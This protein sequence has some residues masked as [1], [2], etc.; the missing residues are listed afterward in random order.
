MADDIPT[1]KVL[2]GDE[3]IVRRSRDA[4][5]AIPVDQEMRSGTGGYPGRRTTVARPVSVSGHGTFAGG[6]QRTLTF[7]PTTREG[8]RFDRTDLADSMPIHVSVDNVW[9]TGAVVSNIVLRSGSPHNYM[10]MAEHIIALRIGLGLDNVLIKMD[11]GDPPLFDRSSAEMVEAIDAAGLEETDA[12]ARY[13][14]VKE[15]VT[16]A[17]ANGSFLT[18]IPARDGERK[19]TVDCAVDFRSAIGKQRILFDVTPDAFRYAALARTNT[20]VG[21]MLYCKTIG[22]I[23]ADIRHLGYTLKNI[24]IAGPRKYV[25]APRLIHEGKCLEA[26]WHR[27]AL[28]LLAA[29]ALIGRGRLAGTVLSYKSGHALDVRMIRELY[30]RDLLEEI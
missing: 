25:N 19:L 10:R 2:V 17:R 28:D 15:P 20:T 18:F 27:A 12:P 8:W 3:T 26:V 11:S 16:V 22:M 13:V 30:L 23:F 4:L 24:Q 29:V 1:G 14:T 21:T 6:A 9:T 5:A 7:E